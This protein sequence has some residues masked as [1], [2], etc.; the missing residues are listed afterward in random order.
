MRRIKLRLLVPLS[1]L[2]TVK[3]PESLRSLQ[4]S[5]P[6][7]PRDLREQC[8]KL[9]NLNTCLHGLFF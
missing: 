2:L 1:K 7:V 4:L 6:T 9:C 8:K 5:E 3:E